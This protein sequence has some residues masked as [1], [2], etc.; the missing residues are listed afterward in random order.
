VTAAD[1]GMDRAFRLRASLIEAGLLVVAALLI[2]GGV[3][4]VRSLWFD[5]AFSVAVARLPWREALSVIRTDAHPPL[6]YLLL[7]VWI[8]MGDS[9][10]VVRGLSAIFGAMTVAATYGFGRR[11]AGR[12][13]GIASAALV[14][15]S[16][17]SIQASAEARMYP[18]LAFFGLMATWALWESARAGRVWMWASYAL[19]LSL[20]LYTDYLAFLLIVAHAIYILAA[21]RATRQIRTGFLLTVVA[22]LLAFIPWWPAAISQLSEERLATVSRGRMPLTAPLEIVALSSFGGYLFGLGGYLVGSLKAAWAQVLL[23]ASFL[24]LGA[25]GAVS[26]PGRGTRALVLTAWAV[27]LGILVLAS[28]GTGIYYAIPRY[29]AY[30]QPFLA[31]LLAQ[32]LLALTGRARGGVRTLSAAVPIVLVVGLNL[33]VLGLTFADARYV[34]YDWAGAAHYVKARWQPGDALLFYPHTARVA[35]GYYFRQQVATAVTLYA[36]PWRSPQA[37]SVWL[38]RLPPA[39]VLV[40]Q[41]RRVWLVLTIP[42]PPETTEALLAKLQESYVQRSFVDFRDVWVLAYERR[43]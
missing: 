38:E 31:I 4:N 30:V 1:R 9:P 36:P 2:R 20:A 13:L 12:A 40:G 24:L 41:A 14:A 18:L 26:L 25:W 22:A 8:Q 6:Y 19:F 11:L 15:A 35:F 3:L 42:T 37:S 33:L 10:T 17:L 39:P 16:A 27:P 43:R 29:A 32:G 21:H 5:E 34:P 7:H 28:L 23:V